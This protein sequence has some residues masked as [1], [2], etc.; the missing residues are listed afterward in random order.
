VEMEFARGGGLA[1][2]KDNEVI[3]LSFPFKTYVNKLVGGRI[4]LVAVV[5]VH[6]R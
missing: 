5:S 3:E 4:R 6:G 1:S 2:I